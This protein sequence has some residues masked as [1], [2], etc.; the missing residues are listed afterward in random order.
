MAD[1]DFPQD[2]LDAQ[3]AYDAADAHVQELLHGESEQLAAAREE[4]LQAVE[5]LHRHEFWQSVD[6]RHAADMALKQA[7]R[8]AAAA[9]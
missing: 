2:L 5:A 3:R 6:N 7:A 9:G 4:R 8:S 1:Y